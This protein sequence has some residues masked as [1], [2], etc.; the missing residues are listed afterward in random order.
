L[1]DVIPPRVRSSVSLQAIVPSLLGWDT[2]LRAYVSLLL[3]LAVAFGGEW[4]VH[5]SVY[6]L[7][8]GARFGAVMADSPHRYYMT[9]LGML[10][11]LTAIGVLLAVAGI[12]YL[13]AARRRYLH[14]VLPARFRRPVPQTQFHLAPATIALTVLALAALQSLIYVVQENLE[15]AAQTGAFPL[16]AVVS[17]A[18]HPAVLPLHLVVA[19]CVACIL[20]ILSAMVTASSDS[21]QASEMLSRLAVAPSYWRL[22]SLLPVL[23]LPSRPQSA[24]C[25]PRAP[26]RAA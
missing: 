21:L 26:P 7:E 23:L 5:Q 15:W 18:A 16:L 24:S 22:D 6:H 4:V 1:P 19:T 20:W 3:F 25:R 2:F 14:A 8:Y 13:Y 12:L 11:G 9:P 10:F 17:P